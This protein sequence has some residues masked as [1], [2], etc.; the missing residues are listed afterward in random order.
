M[1]LLEEGASESEAYSKIW[2]VDS[3]GLIVKD[4]PAGG[5]SGQKIPFAQKHAPIDKLEDVIKTIK[6]TAIIGKVIKISCNYLFVL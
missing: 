1:A 6:P 3:R 2:M 4:R 5:V